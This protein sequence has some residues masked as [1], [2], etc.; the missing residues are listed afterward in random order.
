MAAVLS[1]RDGRSGQHCFDLLHNGFS[2]VLLH[3]AV[4]KSQAWASDAQIMLCGNKSDW[5][6]S[7]ASVVQS[8]SMGS[9]PDIFNKFRKCSIW[10]AKLQCWRLKIIL[11]RQTDG[12]MALLSRVASH[13]SYSSSSQ[14]FSVYL[15]TLDAECACIVFSHIVCSPFCLGTSP[16]MNHVCILGFQTITQMVTKCCGVF[17]KASASSLC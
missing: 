3:T 15:C 17:R 1:E 2:E 9:S 10:R 12:Q 13:T 11:I 14:G 7:F 5:S 8:L 6:E 16:R 4:E